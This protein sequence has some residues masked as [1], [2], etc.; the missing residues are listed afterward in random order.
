MS[1]TIVNLDPEDKRWLDREAQARHVSMTALV[2]EA[3][4][5]YRVRQESMSR[6][7][8]QA[9][10]ERTAGIWRAGDGLEY[11]RRVRA[12]WDDSA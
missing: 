3:V 4:R 2:R 11:Q 1:R 12:E 9:V 10:L 8:V 6:S 7:G 5:D